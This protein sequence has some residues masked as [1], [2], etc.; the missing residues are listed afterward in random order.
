[1][2]FFISIG[3]RAPSPLLRVSTSMNSIQME[4]KIKCK[5]RCKKPH[6]SWKLEAN[7]SEFFYHLGPGKNCNIKSKENKE[8]LETF[9][10]IAI[11]F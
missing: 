3:K 5:K 9:D 7:M 1:M 11:V 4:Q 6:K 8:K 10:Y 2:D